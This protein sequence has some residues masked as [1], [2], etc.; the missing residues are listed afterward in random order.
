MEAR[1]WPPDRGPRPVLVADDD[2][3]IL[4]V[5]STM[6]RLDDLF[7]F[8]CLDGTRAVEIFHEVHPQL[9]ILDVGMP[10]LDGLTVCRKIRATSSVPIIILTVM[11]EPRDAAAALEAGADDYVRKPFAAEELRA[12]IRAVLRRNDADAIRGERVVAGSL[13][14]DGARR[15][16]TVGDAE[17]EL[18]PTEFA[19]LAYLAGHAD[20]ALTHSQILKGVWGSEYMDSPHVLRVTMSRLRQKMESAGA[21]PI[22]TLPRVGYRL[23]RGAARMAAPSLAEVSVPVF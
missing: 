6:L 3:G 13:V 16:A 23:R 21:L 17:L 12:R 5:V 11:N 9:V 4:N 14:V 19:L 20:R 15:L 7:A 10:G 2:Q 18:T 22:E 1:R 8:T